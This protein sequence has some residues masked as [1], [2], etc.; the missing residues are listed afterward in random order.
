MI[1]A[2]KPFVPVYSKLGIFRKKQVF[3]DSA[4]G[5][6]VDHTTLILLLD[7]EGRIRVSFPFDAD[8]DEIVHDIRR[9]L[10]S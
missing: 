6:V 7:R 10:K 4:M 3:S 5:Y 2:R 8:P 1:R 9:L